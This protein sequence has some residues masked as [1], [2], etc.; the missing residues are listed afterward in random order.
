MRGIC[1]YLMDARGLYWITRTS[2]KTYT[3][4]LIVSTFEQHVTVYHALGHK[5]MDHKVFI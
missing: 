4:R 3:Y 1:L 2:V 5:R